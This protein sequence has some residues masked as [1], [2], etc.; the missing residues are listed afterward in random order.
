MQ[1]HIIVGIK[2]LIDNAIDPNYATDGS[3]CF[4]LFAPSDVQISH[5]F[6]TI[7]DLGIAFEVPPMHAM[8]VFSRSGHGFNYDVR[9]SNGTGI[10]DSDYRDSVKLKLTMDEIRPPLWVPRGKAIGQAIILPYPRC[11]FEVRDMLSETVRGTGGF[12]STDA[13]RGA[14]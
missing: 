7:V 12:G 1:H 10:I 13:L 6:P 14:A 5:G 4:D 11:L 3:A 9:L 2:R 8:L